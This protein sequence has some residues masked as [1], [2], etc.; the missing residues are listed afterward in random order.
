[1][2]A[3]RMCSTVVL[4]LALTASADVVAQNPPAVDPAAVSA[5]QQMGAYLRSLGALQVEAVTSD[6]D[7]LDD[8]QKIQYAG[9][10]NILAKLPS[11]LRAEVKNDRFERMY[12]YDGAKFT[13]FAQRP[14]YYATIAAPAK[15]VDLADKLQGSYGFSVPL[16]DLFRWGSP[17]WTPAN[18]TAAMK[19]GPSVVLGTT[20]E[21]YAF[22]QDDV[23]WQIWIQR[24]EFPLPRKIV[25]TDRTDEARPQH[26]AVYT[27][28]LAPS[29]NDAA[30]VFQPPPDAQRVVMSE[31]TAVAAKPV[32]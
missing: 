27:W 3:K 23:D 15:I 24:G 9:V 2:N 17:G 11:R 8:G 13:L 10:T 19:A 18:I 16:E 26:V 12:F 25:I 14:N 22:R 21:Q 29:F 28:N 6:E 20:C 31:S 30:F 7:V 4:A 32:K 1:M 5:L